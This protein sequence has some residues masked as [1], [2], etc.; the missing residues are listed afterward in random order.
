MARKSIPTRHAGILF[1]SRLEA[2]WAVFFDH[3]SLKWE[4]ETQG[5]TVD[6]EPY[7]PDFLVFGALGNIW[8]E[9]KAGWNEDPKGIARW[10]RFAFQRP[11]PSRTVLLTGVPALGNSPFIIGG[12]DDADEPGKGGWDDDTQEW[13][14]CP[15]GI[16]FDLCYP[17][18]WHDLFIEDGCSYDYNVTGS[19]RHIIADACAA[20]CSARF[21]GTAA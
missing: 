14:P 19:G 1:R 21:D 10:K 13:R 5:F 17:G 9:V 18:H 4:Y 6:G 12:D 11:Q 2:R 8:A 16:H 20:A 7:L 15:A 3:L